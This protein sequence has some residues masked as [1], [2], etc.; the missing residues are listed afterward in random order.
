M[1]KWA[2]ERAKSEEREG[3]TQAYCESLAFQVINGLAMIPAC[4]LCFRARPYTLVHRSKACKRRT[5]NY[6][7]L[8][9]RRDTAWM[10]AVPQHAFRQQHNARL[11]MKISLLT[12]LEVMGCNCPPQRQPGAEGGLYGSASM[13]GT[14]TPIPSRALLRAPT[15]ASQLHRGMAPC[16]YSG[17]RSRAALHGGRRGALPRGQQR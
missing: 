6:D 9:P 17:I 11:C 10:Q 5:S 16:A 4:V 15:A 8:S 12:G 14:R 13:W 1:E 2:S 7:K 3:Q